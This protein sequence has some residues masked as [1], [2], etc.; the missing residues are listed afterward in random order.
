M[1]WNPNVNID[2]ERRPAVRDGAKLCRGRAT[3]LW[4]LY[5]ALVVLT[6][7]AAAQG[8]GARHPDDILRSVADAKTAADHEAIAEYFER[9]A[10]DN[11]TLA[12]FHRRL[13]E[14]YSQWHNSYKVNMVQ[15]CE[16]AADEY[17]KIA[18]EN[19]ALAQE[20]RKLA[21]DAK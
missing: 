1:I 12:S 2:C 6:L 9:Q 17:A 8:C 20:H 10:A 21:Q 3:R 19:S 16:K 5:G 13:G 7:I 11:E 4:L 18:A 14:T 15:H